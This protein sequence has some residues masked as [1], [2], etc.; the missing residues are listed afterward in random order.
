MCFLLCSS[1]ECNAT[2]TAANHTNKQTSPACRPITS[3]LSSIFTVP[4]SWE[5][6]FSPLFISSGQ[7]S[8]PHIHLYKLISSLQVKIMTVAT[9]IPVSAGNY[10]ARV[11]L[12]SPFLHS[13]NNMNFKLQ[14]H[15]TPSHQW[16]QDLIKIIAPFA[17]TSSIKSILRTFL[18]TYKE[19]SQQFNIYTLLLEMKENKV[20][21]THLLAI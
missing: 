13:T 19:R 6:F 11:H 15:S 12:L 9:E 8:A 17:P 14:S 1:P 5:C 10:T 3:H 18:Y 2:L 16:D 4:L 20:G 7:S 21:S